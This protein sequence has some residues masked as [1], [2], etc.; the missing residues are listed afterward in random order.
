V[1]IVVE[2]DVVVTFKAIAGNNELMHGVIRLEGL[3]TTNVD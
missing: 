1:G 3:H 2:L